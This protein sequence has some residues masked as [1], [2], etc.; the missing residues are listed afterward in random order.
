MRAR[1]VGLL[2]LA[3]TVPAFAAT[4]FPKGTY[5]SGELA[6][7]FADHGKLE[8]KAKDEVVLNGAWSADADKV[9][10]TDQ[11][12]SYACA[13]PNATGVYTWKSDG[14]AITF[15]KQ[16]DACDDRVQSL[17]GKSWKRKS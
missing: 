12:G 17:D 8:L 2:F 9:T 10:I 1:I 7:T 15:T 4:S 5:M 11:S 16:K 13:A 3:A 6:L 14:G